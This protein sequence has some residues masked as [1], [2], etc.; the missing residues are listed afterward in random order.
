MRMT[1]VDA[2]SRNINRLRE[3]A[4]L[5]QALFG[6]RFGMSQSTVSR[7]LH[8]QIP[9]S[10]TEIAECAEY[11]NVSLDLLYSREGLKKDKY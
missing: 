5:S 10:A 4:G 11:F 3:E 8:G 9:F 7:K 2:L 1:Q 6:E